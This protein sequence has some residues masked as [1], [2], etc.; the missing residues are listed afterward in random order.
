M[1]TFT[2]DTA[3]SANGRGTAWEQQGMCELAFNAAGEHYGMCESG[4]NQF[5]AIR[6][7]S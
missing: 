7:S 3:L 1:R 6:T 4:F 5:S 2:K